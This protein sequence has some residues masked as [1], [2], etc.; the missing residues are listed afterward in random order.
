MNVFVLMNFKI[1]S[2]PND[3]QGGSIK[4]SQC[5]KEYQDFMFDV[6]LFDIPSKDIIYT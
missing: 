1:I 5:V 6:K 4:I 2:L 3:K